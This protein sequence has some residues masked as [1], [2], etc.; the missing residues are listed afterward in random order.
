MAR[1]SLGYVKTEWTC[2]NCNSRNP[3][4]QKTCANC[5]APQPENV[6]F[7]LGAEQ[8]LV[9]DEKERQTAAAGADIHCAFCGARNTA[10]AKTCSQCGADLQEGTKRQAGREMERP[11]GPKTIACTNCGMENQASDVNCAQCGAPLPRA[12]T[13]QVQQPAPASLGALPVSMPGAAAATR[14]P[15]K[16]AWLLLGGIAGAL[17]LCC[18]AVFILFFAP[19]SS[20]PATVSDVFWQTSVPVQEIQPVR[21]TN[22]SGNPP[23]GAYDVSCQT[24]SREV[25]EQ[26]TIDLGN[27]YAEVVE[28]CHTESE[29]YCDYTVDEW[30]TIQTYSLEGNDFSP[31]YPQP[32]ISSSQRYGSESVSYTVNFVTEKGAIPYTPGSLDEFQQFKPGST[33]KLK[34]NAMGSVVGVE[35]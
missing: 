23:S 26:K 11:G 22:E 2:P 4:P 9:T 35:R 3:G 33:W 30:K 24:D 14:A 34:L 29:Q 7:T 15:K 13:P 17:L 18:V 21:Y 31:V 19:T 20:V 16:P 25:C 27:G 8:N 10:T 1:K 6:N 12:A 32:N 5:G 28:E